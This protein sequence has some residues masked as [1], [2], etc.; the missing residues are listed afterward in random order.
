MQEDE[1]PANVTSSMT[2]AMSVGGGGCIFE[3]G[4]YQP[5]GEG[6]IIVQSAQVQRPLECA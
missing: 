3:V 2:G 1:L 5:E 6:C 4:F